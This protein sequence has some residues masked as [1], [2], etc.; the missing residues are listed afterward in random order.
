MGKGTDEKKELQTGITDFRLKHLNAGELERCMESSIK[1]R[2][3]ELKKEIKCPH[4]KKEFEHGV[5]S[6]GRDVMEA[7]KTIARLIGSLQPERIAPAK[8]ESKDS[9]PRLT[10]SEL[11][12]IQRQIDE[13]LGG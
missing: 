2:D 8:S 13:V 3:G 12:D 1:V 11:D 6:S 9:G 4:C 5:F 7:N 10:K